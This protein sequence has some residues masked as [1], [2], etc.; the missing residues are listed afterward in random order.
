MINHAIFSFPCIYLQAYGWFANYCSMRHAK[1]VH[2]FVK[3]WKWSSNWLQILI[4]FLAS[5]ITRIICK[6]ACF[7]I[8]LTCYERIPGETESISNFMQNKI[9][10]FYCHYFEQSCDTATRRPRDTLRL[11][12]RQCKN[13]SI[14]SKIIPILKLRAFS[15]TV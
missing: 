6:F 2:K 11:E 12:Q 13:D 14:Q 3:L 10:L 8:L 5:S 9:Q 1:N 4:D 7:N 15:L